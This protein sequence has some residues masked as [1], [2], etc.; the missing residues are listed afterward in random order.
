MDN[1]KNDVIYK[2]EQNYLKLPMSEIFGI[3]KNDRRRCILEILK[4]EGELSIRSL[5]EEIAR[6]EAGVEEP[7]FIFY[8]FS[9][10]KVTLNACVKKSN[11][12]WNIFNSSNSYVF[13]FPPYSRYICFTQ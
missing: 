3:L 8:V 1:N 4:K 13:F 6:I 2:A 7:N 10:A 11:T 12:F 9:H 5:S